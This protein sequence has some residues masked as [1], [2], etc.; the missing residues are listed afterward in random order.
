MRNSSRARR[1]KLKGKYKSGLENTFASLATRRNLKF[2]YEPET[3]SYIIP[4]HYT[5]DFRIGKNR[6]IETK[7]Y[8]S[9]S[10]RMRLL[11]FK[12]QYPEVEILL[13]FGNEDNKL[14]S[15]SKSTYRQWAEKHGFRCH[16]IRNGLPLEWWKTKK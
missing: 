13:L 5:P 3:F 2:E 11:S 16:D 9:P 12:E 8:L 15:K 4:S 1:K 6:F 14:S 10:N 7:G